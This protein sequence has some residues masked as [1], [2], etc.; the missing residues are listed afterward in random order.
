V[1]LQDQVPLDFPLR[2]PRQRA[3]RPPKADATKRLRPQP[4]CPAAGHGCKAPS[5]KLRVRGPLP[6][7]CSR[8]RVSM[9]LIDVDV[10]GV[11][12]ESD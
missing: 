6:G 1:P 12:W 5:T 2:T 9:A 11:V 10:L 8:C 3:A 7:R 4:N